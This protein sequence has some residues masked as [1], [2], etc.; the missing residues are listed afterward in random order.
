MPGE[1][2]TAGPLPSQGNTLPIPRPTLSEL[3][4]HPRDGG[5]IG[6]LLA[7]VASGKPLLWVQERMAILES[8]D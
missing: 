5:W 3:F 6:F 2:R 7:Q 4:S 1:L 8:G